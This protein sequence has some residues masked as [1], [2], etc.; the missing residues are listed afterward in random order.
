MNIAFCGASGT[1]KTTL[2]KW[3]SD[4]WKLPLNPVGSRSVAREMGFENPYYVDKA[5]QHAY[6]RAIDE[7]KS[8]AEAA[9]VAMRSFEDGQY[10]TCR[11]LF[12]RKLQASKIEWEVANGTSLQHG[13]RP[14]GFV[15]DRTTIDDLVYTMMHDPK[16]V[17]AEFKKRATDHCR[18]YDRVF[19]TPVSVFQDIAEDQKRL[20]NKNYHLLFDYLAGLILRDVVEEEYITRLMSPILEKRQSEV[21]HA[22]AG[23]MGF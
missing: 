17:D 10:G 11:G 16:S 6:L 8:P 1:G 12:Q 20:T 19:F 5:D 9:S 4:C 3:V 13:H 21:N 23:M 2:A 18:V 14:T 7:R 15:S 22:I